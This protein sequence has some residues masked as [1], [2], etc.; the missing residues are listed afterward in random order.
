MLLT[1]EQIL[2]WRRLNPISLD[3]NPVIL[4]LNLRTAN[5]GMISSKKIIQ[6]TLNRSSAH[7]IL[8]SQAAGA[9]PLPNLVKTHS[10]GA[11]AQSRVGLHSQTR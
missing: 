1:P 6:T 4:I 2:Q 10:N 5:L 8:D 3:C 7:H 9:V 11:Q